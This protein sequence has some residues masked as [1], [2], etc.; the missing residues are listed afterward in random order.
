[1]PPE[2]FLKIATNENNNFGSIVSTGQKFP[3][4]RQDDN[5]YSLE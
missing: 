3:R 2:K 4:I 1:M 5:L